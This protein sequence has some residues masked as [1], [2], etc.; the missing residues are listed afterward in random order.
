[1]YGIRPHL[2]MTPEEDAMA[3]KIAEQLTHP[4]NP[5]GIY[6]E[7]FGLPADGP[8]PEGIPMGRDIDGKRH[9]RR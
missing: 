2:P 6:R 4:V 7:V 8:I 9:R 5:S 3:R 1:M